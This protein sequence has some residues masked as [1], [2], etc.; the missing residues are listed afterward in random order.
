MNAVDF[1]GLDCAYMGNDGTTMESLDQNS[2]SGECAANG[3]YWA[4]GGITNYQINPNGSYTFTS[5][6]S[7]NNTIYTTYTTIPY[8]A[9]GL[10]MSF[11]GGSSSDGGGGGSTAPN[12]GHAAETQS[13]PARYYS[14]DPKL[15]WS[16]LFG[17]FSPIL[18]WTFCF[19]V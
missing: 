16:R 19:S 2:N 9:M 17:Q 10:G 6:G 8:F 1:D 5:L 15:R 3:G 4:D 13:V 18:K 7:Q 12:N 11:G 14:N